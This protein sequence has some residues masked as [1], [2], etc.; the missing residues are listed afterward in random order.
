MLAYTH[1]VINLPPLLKKKKYKKIQTNKFL[2]ISLTFRNLGANL[3]NPY[4]LRTAYFPNL[5]NDV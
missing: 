2:L 1:W 5:K 4:S 3:F